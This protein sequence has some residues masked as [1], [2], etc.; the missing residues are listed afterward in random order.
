MVCQEFTVDVWFVG[1][2]N[3]A[4]IVIFANPVNFVITVSLAHTVNSAISATTVSFATY[5]T[6]ANG[7][8]TCERIR[9]KTLVFERAYRVEK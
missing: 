9:R 5:V 3:L 6:G 4:I 7:A 1:L 8:D 2:V